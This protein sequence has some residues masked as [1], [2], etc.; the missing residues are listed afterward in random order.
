MREKK[1]KKN[2]TIKFVHDEYKFSILFK[3]GIKLAERNHHIEKQLNIY[4]YILET[5]YIRIRKIKIV[6]LFPVH[7]VARRDNN[8]ELWNSINCWN[9]ISFAIKKNETSQIRLVTRLFI[10]IS[11]CNW[12]K[13]QVR[14]YIC[15][16]IADLGW[17]FITRKKYYIKNTENTINACN[18]LSILWIAF[19]PPG[20]TRLGNV[21]EFRKLLFR[22]SIK[23]KKKYL[24]EYLKPIVKITPNCIS[25][26]RNGRIYIKIYR[27][28]YRSLPFS[29]IRLEKTLLNDQRGTENK[30]WK[31]HFRPGIRTINFPSLSRNVFAQNLAQ[32][33]EGRRAIT[34]TCLAHANP[35]SRNRNKRQLRWNPDKVAGFECFQSRWTRHKHTGSLSRPFIRKCN[36]RCIIAVNRFDLSIYE[37]RTRGLEIVP[38][39]RSRDLYREIS[40]LKALFAFFFLGMFSV[41]YNTCF[42]RLTIIITKLDIRLIPLVNWNLLRA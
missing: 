22:V 23:K 18:E 40:R 37:I 28:K 5:N 36:A 16:S 12:I 7:T 33:I 14:S 2:V 4:L 6:I 3:K 39:K 26:T 29:I 15:I 42:L 10:S 27:K 35:N 20:F 21:M 24:H 38:R 9:S 25:I 32:C 31:T 19:D 34:C 17:L 1:K 8:L 11:R 41:Y 30:N 13:I